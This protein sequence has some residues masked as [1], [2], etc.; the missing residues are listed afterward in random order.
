MAASIGR[1]GII[2][3]TALALSACV[4]GGKTTEPATVSP[5]QVLQAPASYVALPEP[6][7]GGRNLADPIQVTRATTASGIPSA[8]SALVR[9]A[10]RFG[11]QPVLGAATSET[12]N[13]SGWL[14]RWFGNNRLFGSSQSQ[15]LDPQQEQARLQAAGIGG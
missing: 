8:D 11:T 12:P 10:F 1:F 14:G 6:T 2:T 7:P 3:I 15:L 9:Y 5:W 13:R 4:G